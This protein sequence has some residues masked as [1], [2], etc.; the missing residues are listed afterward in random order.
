MSK[1]AC[2]VEVKSLEL[3]T[4][5]GK[6]DVVLLL[7]AVRVPVTRTSSKLCPPDT[8]SKVT[9]ITDDVAGNITVV[10]PI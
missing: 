8:S 6:A 2:P 1:V 10:Y 7:G 4:S 9:L 3:K 5:I